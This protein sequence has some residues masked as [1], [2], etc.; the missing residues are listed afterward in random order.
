ML[1]EKRHLRF[2]PTC[3]IIAGAP[4]SYGDAARSK[5]VASLDDKAVTVDRAKMPR[6]NASDQVARALSDHGDIL[7]MTQKIDAA[8]LGDLRRNDYNIQLKIAT[9]PL[10]VSRANK[11]FDNDRKK[12]ANRSVIPEILSLERQQD[13]H[14]NL[15][16]SAYHVEQKYMVDKIEFLRPDGKTVFSNDLK[17]PRT[18][19]K[20]WQNEPGA[21]AAML[22]EQI[23]PLSIKER[24]VFAALAGADKNASESPYRDEIIEYGKNQARYWHEQLDF[25]SKVRASSDKIFDQ[26]KDWIQRLVAEG[27]RVK[28]GVKSIEPLKGYGTD[29]DV[30]DIIGHIDTAIHKLSMEVMSRVTDRRLA[31]HEATMAE[32]SKPPRLDSASMAAELYIERMRRSAGAA[33]RRP[34]RSD[35]NRGHDGR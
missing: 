21:V 9:S 14:V 35:R 24:Q 13:I 8:F 29:T 23:R 11:L 7:F 19:E 4:E 16:L 17:D 34:S 2:R 20:G 15:L 22:R 33:D 25:D 6:R 28:K 5:A 12:A 31:F 27:G 3:I 26:A 30:A 32:I 10:N 1:D 18:P